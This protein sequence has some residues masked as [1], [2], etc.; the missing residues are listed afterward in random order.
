MS[1]IRHNGNNP[2]AQKPR[3]ADATRRVTSEDFK[4]RLKKAIFAPNKDGRPAADKAIG[5]FSGALGSVIRVLITAT[6]I[7]AITGAI[8]A[9]V[10][11]A[12]VNKYLAPGA[13]I[14]LDSLQL[15]YTSM[16]YY[17]DAQGKEQELERLYGEQNR[18][19]AD[20]DEIPQ[21]MKDAIVAIEDERFWKHHGVDWKRTVGATVQ[22]ALG[23]DFY[24][25]S[26]ITQQLI[27]NLTGDTEVTIQRKVQE[28]L[29]ATRLEKKYKK[30]QILEMYLNTIPLSQGCYGVRSAAQTYFNKDIS[31]LSIA[32]C[33]AIAGI[34]N[35]P[36]Y[37]DPFINPDHNKE[38]QKNILWKMHD[39]GMITDE[40]YEKAKNET[41]EFKKTQRQEEV[42]SKQSYFVDQVI[43]DVID[44]LVANKGYTEQLASRLVYSGG[45]KIYATIDPKV[46]SVLD[47]V[48][49]NNKNFPTLKGVV[50]PESAMVVMSSEG[51]VVGMV[52]GRGEKVINR[53]LNRATQSK[54]QPGSSIKPL[55]VYAPA[56]EYG[57]IT[58]YSIVDDAPVSEL[59]GKPYPKNYYTGY[60]GLETVKEAVRVSANAP[61]MRI[62]EKL[63]VEKSFAFAKTNLGLSSLVDSDKAR[64]PLALGGLTYGVTPLELTA[65]YVPFANE[66]VYVKPR[67]Y[68]KVLDTNGE[69]L[70]DNKKVEEVV[71]SEKTVFYMNDMLT[72]VMKNG[73]GTPA[74]LKNMPSG[75]K[76]GTTDDDND[77]WFVGYTPYYVAAVWFGF[78]IPKELSELSVNPGS[79]VWKTVMEKLHQGKQVKD[80][81]Q[82]KD[83][84][85]ASYCMDSGMKPTPLCE[86]DARGSRVASGYFAKED[87]P[88]SACTL[89][90]SVTLCTE[91]NKIA[92]D[93]CPETTRKTVGMVN[94]KRDYDPPGIVIDDR[95]YLY[96]PPATNP[97]E[98]NVTGDSPPPAGMGYCDIHTA[99]TVG[100]TP[101][102]MQQWYEGLFPGYD[103]DGLI[104]PVSED[105]PDNSRNNNGNGNRR[106]N[107]N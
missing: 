86:L 96:Q 24:G 105:N 53:G 22:I 67:T 54:R 32:E 87:V 35:L 100:P 42:N 33:A 36:T 49:Q 4:K 56:I 51:D 97:S 7:L 13:N 88:K 39:L 80:F 81:A 15:N 63:G 27:K 75:G 31:Q 101:E 18:V 44:D 70:L 61:A 29:R 59:G 72:N 57:L 85:T 48:Y 76:T 9:S 60:R 20:Y 58:P 37:Y 12:Y 5:M 71:M 55:A 73:T 84:V 46:Q 3:Q 92:T 17:V 19:W 90:V 10:F 62:L 77:R 11:A 83:F 107:D 38:R 25:G 65:A 26:T 106:G 64:A 91:S 78:D 28:I 45:L 6:I 50:Q 89:H 99:D 43:S 8:C 69:V 2:E 74:R 104:P 66:G 23:S 41:L 52:G 21:A 68:T 30:E 98:G 95:N 94:Y 79:V 93:Y 16:V 103:G 102:D 1:D 47:G 40:E 34:T 14:E 82:P